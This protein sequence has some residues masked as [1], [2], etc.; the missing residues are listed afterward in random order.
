M[1]S[2]MWMSTWK[3]II[4]TIFVKFTQINEI[5]S[6]SRY[7]IWNTC[8]FVWPIMPVCHI[9]FVVNPIFWNAIIEFVHPVSEWSGVF[10]L[11]CKLFTSC[12]VSNNTSL[13]SARTGGQGG[14]QPNV[15]RPG[16]EVGGSKKSHI[17]ADIL[18]GWFLRWVFCIGKTDLVKQKLY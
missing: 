13:V 7:W 2:Q 16:Q 10:T 17:C 6:F 3:D 4:A 14:R 1:V 9:Y 15:D 18:Y 8:I 12:N 5:F 11:Q